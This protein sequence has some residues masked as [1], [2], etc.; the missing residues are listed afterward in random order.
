MHISHLRANQQLLLLLLL[1]HF[2]DFVGAQT[3]TNPWVTR[4]V[5]AAAP[6]QLL[7]PVRG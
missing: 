3:P 1:L 5:F 2:P 4:P 7:L 6:R